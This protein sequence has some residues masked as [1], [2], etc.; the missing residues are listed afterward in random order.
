MKLTNELT[1]ILFETGGRV[2][3]DMLLARAGTGLVAG[4]YTKNNQT[5]QAIIDELWQIHRENKEEIRQHY[6]FRIDTGAVENTAAWLWANGYG[7]ASPEAPHNIPDDIIRC[8]HCSSNSILMT[9]YSNLYTS[10]HCKDC[11]KYFTKENK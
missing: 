2:K 1:R 7:H 4:K 5:N 9:N 3:I 11:R 8:V 10:F 6:T